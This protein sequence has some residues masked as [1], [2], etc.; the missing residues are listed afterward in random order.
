MSKSTAG[1]SPP[2]LSSS[3][4]TSSVQL[5]NKLDSGFG[6][7]ALRRVTE[8]EA[9]RRGWTIVQWN[10]DARSDNS[11]ARPG[12]LARLEAWRQGKAGRTH[13]CQA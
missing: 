4:D 1:P 8:D 11:L 2:K 9:D 7:A 13:G 10:E 12:L 6:L 3:L 5:S